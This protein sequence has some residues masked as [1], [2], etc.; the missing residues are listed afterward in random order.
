VN[1]TFVGLRCFST[2]SFSHL[3]SKGDVKMVD[4]SEKFDTSRVATAKGYIEMLPSTLDLISSHQISKG[5]VLATAKIAG[6]MAA[7]QTSNLVPLCHPL[8]IS[9]V[10]LEF[11]CDEKNSRI[12]VSATVKCV[13]KTGVEMEALISVSVAC[14]TIY[15][16]CKAVDKGMI[17]SNIYV[18]EKKGL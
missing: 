13:G 8:Q 4:V 1:A 2:K 9:Q 17:I 6:I 16:M 10:D 3:D 15:D 7:K 18:S 5:N 12:H 14:C 11:E